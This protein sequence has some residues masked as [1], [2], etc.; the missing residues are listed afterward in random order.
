MG[1]SSSLK[2][3][4][5]THPHPWVNYFTLLSHN[6]CGFLEGA[7][8]TALKSTEQVLRRHQQCQF[9]LCTSIFLSHCGL[10]I[11]QP[12]LCPESRYNLPSLRIFCFPM[13]KCPGYVDFFFLGISWMKEA[14]IVVLLYGLGGQWD[15]LAP[16]PGTPLQTAMERCSCGQFAFPLPVLCR[17][18]WGIGSSRLLNQ[19]LSQLPVSQNNQLS[20]MQP[21][22]SGRITQIKQNQSW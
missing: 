11:R 16:A 21:N 9:S 6:E 18:T 7:K 14:L 22:G 8:L 17:Q 20:I 15:W 5:I 10:T 13:Q 4:T 12:Q 3:V 2:L 19:H 1:N